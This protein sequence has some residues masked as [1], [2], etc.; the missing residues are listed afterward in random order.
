MLFL[1]DE[2][3]RILVICLITLKNE[4]IINIMRNEKEKLLLGGH[5]DSFYLSA[6]CEKLFPNI[7]LI[8]HGNG[9]ILLFL[10]LKSLDKMKTNSA[11][12]VNV[13]IQVQLYNF[14]E[15]YH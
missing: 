13:H 3:S 4:L 10:S 7:A 5:R 9:N 11:R 15:I 14:N 8:N 12:F 2:K 1:W 6:C